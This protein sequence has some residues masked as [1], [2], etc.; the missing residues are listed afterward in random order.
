M[1]SINQLIS[2]LSIMKNVLINREKIY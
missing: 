2:D 1:K